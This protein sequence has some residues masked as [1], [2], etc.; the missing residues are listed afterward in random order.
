MQ[1]VSVSGPSSAERRE[2][3]QNKTCIH[4]K[5]CTE[6][7]WLKG[8]GKWNSAIIG[9]VCV[10]FFIWLTKI[11][12]PKHPALLLPWICYVKLKISKNAQIICA[13]SFIYCIIYYYAMVVWLAEE[14]RQ[15][16]GLSVLWSSAFCTRD[17][18]YSLGVHSLISF[19]TQHISPHTSIPLLHFVAGKLCLLSR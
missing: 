5:W 16:G 8:K 11:Y 18:S 12:G 15:K 13:L 3:A 9:L 7:A 14:S 4:K 19:H 1:D 6:R 10:P 2:G 17:K